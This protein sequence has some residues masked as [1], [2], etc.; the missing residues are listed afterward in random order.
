MLGQG[1]CQGR[2]I[3]PLLP[4][5]RHGDEVAAEHITILIIRPQNARVQH[6]NLQAQP[7]TLQAVDSLVEQP[8]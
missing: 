1:E 5:A 3:L 4:V 7:A 6:V 8:A 2:S